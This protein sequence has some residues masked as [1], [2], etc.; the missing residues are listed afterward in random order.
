MTYTATI[1]SK[2]QLTIPVEIFKKIGFKK[3]E[4]VLVEEQ[5]DGVKIISTLSR[6]RKL[7]GSLKLAKKYKGMDLDKLI[8]V[9][10]E[11]YYREKFLR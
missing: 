4:K 2:R 6:L 8:D 10:R 1:T 3:G 7:A 9:A 11:K 5:E